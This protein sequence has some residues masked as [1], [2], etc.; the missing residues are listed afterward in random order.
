MDQEVIAGVGNVYRAEVLFRHRH[1]PAAA[2]QDA[3]ARPVPGDVGRPGGADGE[4]VRDRPHRHGARRAHP[5]GDGPAPARDDHGGEVYVYRRHGR[6]ATSAARRSAPRCSP[7]ATCSGARGASRS[8]APAPAGLTA[9]RRVGRSRSHALGRLAPLR[10]DPWSRAAPPTGREPA[11]S[12]GGV[13]TVEQDDP[14]AARGR[15]AWALMLVRLDAGDRRRLVCD[16][17]ARSRSVALLIPMVLANLRARPA[18]LPWFVVFVLGVVVVAVA[19]APRPQLD[20]PPG[21]RHRGRVHDRADRAGLARSGGPGSAWQALA[22]S[23]CWSTCAS[24]STSRARSPSCRQRLVR[25][26]GDAVRRGHVVRRRLHGRQPRPRT[27]ARLRSPWS[28]C[29]ARASRPAPGRCCSPGAFGGLLG[30]LPPA[31]FLPAANEYLLRQDWSEGFATAIHL[32]L[33]LGTGDFE[34][35]AAGH[36]PAI[37]LHAGSGRWAVHDGRGPGPRADARGAEFTSVTGMLAA[38]RR[39]AAVHRRPRGDP[40]A[41]H[42]ARHRQA[43]RPGRAAAARTGSRTAPRRLIDRLE[44]LNDDCALLLLHRR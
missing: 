7:G 23:R 20:A 4:G 44:P 26:G 42:L 34:I 9:T 29:P 35:R 5:R 19:G 8:S 16:C 43:D 13:A 39:A 1:P 22:A 36:P 41:R 28:T 27:A 38:R 6:P 17:R 10:S 31:E 11:R 2:G 24:G 33:D 25:R 15:P 3:A 30:A 14:P 21:R 37:Q 12:P 40:A 18:P 32:S